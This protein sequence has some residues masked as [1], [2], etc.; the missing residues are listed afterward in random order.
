MVGNRNNFSVA[1]VEV[2][3]FRIFSP[4]KLITV[5]LCMIEMLCMFAN[6]YDHGQRHERQRAAKRIVSASTSSLG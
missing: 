1:F 4:F 2:D 3:P 6:V 5:Q